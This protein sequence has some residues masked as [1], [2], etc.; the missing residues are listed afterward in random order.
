ME[1]ED[2]KEQENK[3]V[4]EEKLE[5][6]KDKGQ[7]DETRTEEKEK[8]KEKE[9]ERQDDDRPILNEGKDNLER[10]KEMKE[11]NATP[12]NNQIRFYSAAS[13]QLDFK[14]IVYSCISC[15]GC[16]TRRDECDVWP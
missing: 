11:E 1:N 2:N 4:K 8:L 6:N 7:E 3:M 16:G 15:A 10:N 12:D 5:K 14:N 9:K 13:P